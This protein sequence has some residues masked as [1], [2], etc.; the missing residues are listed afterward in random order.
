MFHASDELQLMAMHFKN[1]NLLA[2]LMFC[3]LLAAGLQPWLADSAAA[4]ETRKMMALNIYADERA[5]KSFGR[6]S[7]FM[8][9]LRRAGHVCRVS[10]YAYGG[11]INCGDTREPR[12]LMGFIFAP[13]RA[14][15]F[16]IIHSIRANG[17]NG[18]ELVKE[19]F[20]EFLEDFLK[21]AGNRPK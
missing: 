1:R 6:L 3:G 14:P 12:V 2:K 13:T 16:L 20:D 21:P 8:Q 9:K 11:G 17:I 10:D 5:A 4:L 18:G 15:E 19:K 7:A